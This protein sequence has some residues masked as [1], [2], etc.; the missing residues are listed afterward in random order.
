MYFEV[1]ITIKFD[2][3][4]DNTDH[5][6]IR[7]DSMAGHIDAAPVLGL[8]AD[9]VAIDAEVSPYAEPGSDAGDHAADL[10]SDRT[11]GL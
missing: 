5:A 10:A 11:V 9:E 2:I 4:A 8:D 3:E 7:A 1:T 6:I